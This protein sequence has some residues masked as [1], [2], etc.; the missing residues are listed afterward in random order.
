M[1]NE[2]NTQE[3]AEKQAV[4][5]SSV[6]NDEFVI[7]FLRSKGMLKPK[8]TRFS[9]GGQFGNDEKLVQVSLNELLIEYADLINKENKSFLG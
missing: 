6:N 4:V 2:L 8:F 9:I 5:S 7:K 1:D 3:E